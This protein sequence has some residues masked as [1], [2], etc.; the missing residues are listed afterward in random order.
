[1]GMAAAPR[2]LLGLV[3]R[4]PPSALGIVFPITFI[5]GVRLSLTTV[6]KPSCP[7]NL[8]GGELLFTSSKALQTVR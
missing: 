2:V 6:C 7:P 5:L 1:M 4:T 8:V 3:G